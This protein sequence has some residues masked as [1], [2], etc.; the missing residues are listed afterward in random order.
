M[1]S[2]G[3]GNDILSPLLEREGNVL[4]GRLSRS[5]DGGN[6]RDEGQKAGGA[7]E[8]NHFVSEILS[9]IVWKP[10]SRGNDLKRKDAARC[11]QWSYLYP[12]R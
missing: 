4:L 3:V 8:V 9:E 7:D 2:G 12:S 11:P 10:M 6:E 5:R 1:L